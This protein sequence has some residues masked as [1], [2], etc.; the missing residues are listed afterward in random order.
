MK[1]LIGVTTSELRPGELATLRR[2]GEPPNPEMALGMTYVRAIEAAGAIPVVLP[3]VGHHDVP[4]LLDRLDGVV[5]SGGPDLAPAAYGAEPHLELG[6]TEPGLDA[7][8]YAVAREAL[9]LA[10]PILGIC[11]GAQTLNVARG[12]T[13]HQHLPDVVGDAIEHRQT[14]DGRVPTHP[15]KVL[16]GSRLA[17]TLGV[18]QLSVNSFHHQA[19]DRLGTGLRACAWA[20]DGTIE[21]IED[22]DQAFVVAVQWHA[23]TLQRVP[24]QLALFEGLVGVAAAGSTQLRRAA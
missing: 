8:E 10:L 3:P 1:S 24:G 21:A 17:A 14:V 20:P 15:V 23:E 9:R 4:G 11:R 18:T 5:L 7:F 22:P 16:P 2:H 12:G 13:L 19:I 6:S